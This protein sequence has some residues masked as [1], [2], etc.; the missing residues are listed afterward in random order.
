MRNG[1]TEADVMATELQWAGVSVQD[2][3]VE[4]ESTNT[5]EN[6]RNTAPMLKGYEKIYLVTTGIHMKRAMLFFKHFVTSIDP[7]PADKMQA[8]VTIIPISPNL[9]FFD[10]ALLEYLGILQYKI[11]NLMGWNPPKVGVQ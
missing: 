3:L 7:A 5:F 9:I 1:K 8:F 6:A 10:F 2:L 11:Y 4:T